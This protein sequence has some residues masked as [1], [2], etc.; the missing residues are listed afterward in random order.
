VGA[1]DAFVDGIKTQSPGEWAVRTGERAGWTVH[2]EGDA[3]RIA[4]AL[5]DRFRAR[6]I[7]Q[8]GG[9]APSGAI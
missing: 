9:G 4:R 8:R 1:D 6:E 2:L 5:F 7:V 3:H